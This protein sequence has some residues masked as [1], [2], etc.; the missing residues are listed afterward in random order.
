MLDSLPRVSFSSQQ[1]SVCTFWSSQRQLIQSNN[2]ATTFLDPLTSRFCNSQSG[3]AQFWDLQ[4]SDIVR[5]SSY[6]DD[7]FTSIFLG[8]G[9]LA[10]DETDAD[11]RTVDT[12]LEETLENRF[13]EPGVGAAGE[14]SVELDKEKEVHVLRGRGLA[15]TLADM[16]AFG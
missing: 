4:H 2:L 8:V 7:R 13:V 5:D 12:R 16:V 14:E 9:D 11:G 3:N 1:E 15:V 6:D 10:V